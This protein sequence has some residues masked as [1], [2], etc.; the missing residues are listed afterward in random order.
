LED[1][2][3]FLRDLDRFR[4][5]ARVWI[6]LAGSGSAAVNLL[7]DYANSMGARHEGLRLRSTV[8]GYLPIE[9]VRY[10]FSDSL[11]L[12]ASSADAFPITIRA[13]EAHAVM[14]CTVGPMSVRPASMT[15]SSAVTRGK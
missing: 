3:G 13:A 5:R 12:A 10:D 1:P 11:R 2:R 14:S 4:G 6:I 9:V 7:L 8:P 15:S